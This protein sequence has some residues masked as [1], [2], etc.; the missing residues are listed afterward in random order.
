MEKYTQK[1]VFRTPRTQAQSI[2]TNPAGFGDS[3]PGV[4]PQKMAK[5]PL[6]ASAIDLMKMP[7]KPSFNGT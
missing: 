4:A 2:G 7:D 1:G 6:A 5:D 3:V